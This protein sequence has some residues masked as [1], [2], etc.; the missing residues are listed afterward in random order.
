MLS[1]SFS[2]LATGTMLW[3]F[4]FLIC[5]GLGYPTLNRYDPGKANPDASEY[6]KMVRSEGDVAIHFRHRVLVPHLARPIFRATVGRVGSWDPA[7][8]ALLIVN[9]F[10]VSG[11]AF[12]LFVMVFRNMDGPHIA[13][14]SSAI[15]LLNFAVPNLLLAGL[16]DSGEAFFL[17]ALVWALSAEWFLLLPFIVALG[18]LAKETF[19]PFALVFAATWMILNRRQ[20][21]PG[22]QVMW[23]MAAA[24]A[25][26]ASLTAALTL[27]NGHLLFPWTYAG[28]LRSNVA[29]P[30]TALAV[31]KDLNFWYVFAWLL[32]LGLFRL[33]RLPHEWVTAA[34]IT[35]SVA[36]AFTAFHN[37]AQDAGAAV[38]RPVFS[39]AGPLLSV[40]VALLIVDLAGRQWAGNKKDFVA[41]GS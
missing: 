16:V 17:M 36:I 25:G 13:M 30:A 35:S 15:Y 31:L 38:A 5:F 27:T 28:M 23:L 14:A 33:K 41:K 20:G 11:T 40:S 32:P 9:S 7:N 18:S 26:A 12:L 34:F 8:F 22:K 6:L 39:I 3:S 1:K 24:A 19:L 37:N 10:F 29:S 2:K 4:F 21:S